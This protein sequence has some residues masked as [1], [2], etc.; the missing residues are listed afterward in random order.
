[1][2]GPNPAN[3]AALAVNSAKGQFRFFH[4]QNIFLCSWISD[5]LQIKSP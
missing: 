3:T 1:M 4:T 2:N 5:L